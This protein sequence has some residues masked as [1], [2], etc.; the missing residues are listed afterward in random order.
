MQG[1]EL[2]P[3]VGTEGEI[4]RLLRLDGV[5]LAALR[6]VEVA[7]PRQGVD[8][9]IVRL[10]RPR[11]VGELVHRH[12]VEVHPK[13]Q[14]AGPELP[15]EPDDPGLMVRLET[16][17]LRG[18]LTDLAVRPGLPPTWDRHDAVDVRGPAPRM[19]TSGM[20]QDD[21]ASR[22]AVGLEG[23][24]GGLSEGEVRV[25]VRRDGSLGRIEVD[26]PQVRRATGLP[27][28]LEGRDDPSRLSLGPRLRATQTASVQATRHKVADF[29]A[30]GAPE[31]VIDALAGVWKRHTDPVR[32]IVLDGVPRQL[33]GVC[34]LNPVTVEGITLSSIQDRGVRGPRFPLA[35]GLMT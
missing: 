2:A 27:G 3:V 25:Q 15:L 24:V 6:V 28:P 34:D 29:A 26:M 30:A 19:T 32:E 14:A 4:G 12:G 35:E 1:L 31:M 16:R 5:P 18:R 9:P 11:G 13:G 7:P 33:L 20:V 21:R 17:G 10:L 23:D 22:G 8:G